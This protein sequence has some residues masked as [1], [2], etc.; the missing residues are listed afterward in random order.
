MKATTTQLSEVGTLRTPMCDSTGK[1][2]VALSAPATSPVLSSTT[3]A[4]ATSLV[5]KAAAGIL[6]GV[7]GYNSKGTPQFLQIHDAAAL[8]ADTAVPKIV[9]SVP[10]SSSFALEFGMGRG[11]A[12]GIVICNSSTGPT[13]TIGAADIWVDAQYI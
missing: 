5:V 3:P 9:I 11:F 2:L 6:Y 12:N 4:Y 13:K 8:P 10:A 1:L 7:T